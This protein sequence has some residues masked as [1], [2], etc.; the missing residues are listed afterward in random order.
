[1]ESKT[2][3]AQDQLPVLVASRTNSDPIFMNLALLQDVLSKLEKG[4]ITVGFIETQAATF[5]FT[6]DSMSCMYVIQAMH[7][8]A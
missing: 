4:D 3:K 5:Q 7:G 2:G 6:S 1:M 8:G